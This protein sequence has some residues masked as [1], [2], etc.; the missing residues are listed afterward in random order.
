MLAITAFLLNPTPEHRTW[1]TTTLAATI[2]ALVHFRPNSVF[3][4]A[5]LFLLLL[6]KMTASKTMRDSLQLSWA[7]VVFVSVIPLSL[8]HNVFYGE[9]FA[10]FTAVTNSEFSWSGTWSDGGLKEVTLVLWGQLRAI[11]Y[12]R[13]P[14]DPSYMIFFWGS[15][16]ALLVT[17]VRLGLQRLLQ[18][19]T[20][21]AGL[22][23]IS[24]IL[25][26]LQF[27]IYP[28]NYYPRHLVAA[29]LLCLVAG[30]LLWTDTTRR[31]S[32]RP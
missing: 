9:N 23:P 22:I 30:L 12:W 32:Q 19:T 6:R 26:M 11:M 25:P 4:S 1:V 27:R 28:E 8:L 5:I 14:H 18:N 16:L 7:I 29:S 15:Q 13:V 2:A 3:A 21:L 31:T 24:Y 20:A 10:P 17:L